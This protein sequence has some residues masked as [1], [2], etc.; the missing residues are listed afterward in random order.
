[1]IEVYAKTLKWLR[2]VE[3]AEDSAG[4]CRGCIL[5]KMPQD[6]IEVMIANNV[7]MVYRKPPSEQ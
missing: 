5:D 2:E 7:T 3:F 4:G 1:M 6:L